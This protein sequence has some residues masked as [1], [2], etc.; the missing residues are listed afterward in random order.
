[1]SDGTRSRFTRARRR[2]GRQHAVAVRPSSDRRL[3]TSTSPSSSRSTGWVGASLRLE[4][5]GW[6]FTDRQAAEEYLAGLQRTKD[7]ANGQ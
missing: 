5:L 7:N 6:G 2:A 1:M 3:S 4:T